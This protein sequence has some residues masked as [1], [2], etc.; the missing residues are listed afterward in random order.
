MA[1]GNCM[2]KLSTMHFLVVFVAVAAITLTHSGIM[3]R[4]S[5]K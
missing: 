4:V 3:L 1:S 2:F 5:P